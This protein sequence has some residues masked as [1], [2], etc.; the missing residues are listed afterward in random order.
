MRVHQPKEKKMTEEMIKPEDMTGV[1]TEVVLYKNGIVAH[2]LDGKLHREGDK[3][4]VIERKQMNEYWLHGELH[5][6]GDKPAVIWANGTVEH[7]QRGRKHRDGDKPA[8]IYLN[9]D[10][11]YWL[12]GKQYEP[13]QGV[14]DD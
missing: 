7:Y 6:E 8:V 1:G 3:P 2:Y 10:V 5:R 4:A 11:Q 12:H 13:T 9:G 14:Q